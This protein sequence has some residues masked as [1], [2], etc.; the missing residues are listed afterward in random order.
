M[1]QDRKWEIVLYPDSD[2][3]DCS[4]ILAKLSEFFEQ[5][6]YI[7]HDKDLDA[8]GQPKKPHYHFYGKSA[9]KLT[10]SGISYGVGVPESACRVVSRWKGALRYLVHADNPEKYQYDV[11]D[12]SSNIPLSGIFA[13]SDDIQAF[14]I[15]SY[16]SDTHC[17]S[18]TTLT[19]WAIQ[20]GYYSGLRR[21]FAI[22]SQLLRENSVFIQKDYFVQNKEV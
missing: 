6:A 2:S 16:I 8:D 10:S 20:N 5:W 13:V 7:L 12:I 1:K 15:F 3:Y 17:T 19:G 18:V 14:R 9:D 4:E 21:G 11:S 22:F